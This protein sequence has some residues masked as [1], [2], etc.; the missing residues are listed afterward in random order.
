MSNEKSQKTKTNFQEENYASTNI[1]EEYQ[2]NNNLEKIIPAFNKLKKKSVIFSNLVGGTSAI[3]GS[4]FVVTGVVAAPFT[5]GLS[6][7]ITLLGGT[8]GVTGS[9]YSDYLL[10]DLGKVQDWLNKEIKE[11]EKMQHVLRNENKNLPRNNNEIELKKLLDLLN[12]LLKIVD[13]VE[14]SNIFL[15][16][17]TQNGLDKKRFVKELEDFVKTHNLRKNT[18]I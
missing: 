12:E 9:Y 10:Y 4:I 3:F 13:L 5:A 18:A 15:K 8:I 14:D 16:T 6:L 2:K 17:K 11:V 1:W 7:T